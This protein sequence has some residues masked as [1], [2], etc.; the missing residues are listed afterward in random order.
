MTD[1]KTLYEE[2]GNTPP[3]PDLYPAIRRRIARQ[4]IRSRMLF[5][6]ASALI[7][8]VTGTFRT[9]PEISAGPDIAEELQ[10]IRDYCNGTD[11]KQAIE[12]YAGLDY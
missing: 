11:L 7:I 8:A 6:L 2:L 12:L 4:A 9:R 5:A 3:L 10:D 1:E